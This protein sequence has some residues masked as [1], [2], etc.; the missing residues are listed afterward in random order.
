MAK[1]ITARKDYGVRIGL[2]IEVANTTEAKVIELVEKIASLIESNIPDE[3]VHVGYDAEPI[4]PGT[5][6][7][8]EDVPRG[9]WVST[10]VQLSRPTI[11][12]ITEG[13][14]I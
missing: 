10:E 5:E 11:S 12:D 6:F 3:L 14:V 8:G 1:L 9:A 7:K 4:S 2:A 13:D